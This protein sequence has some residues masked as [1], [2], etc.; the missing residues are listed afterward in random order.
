MNHKEILIKYY[1]SAY[2][3][4]H[5]SSFPDNIKTNVAKVATSSG[6]QKGVFTVLVTLLVHKIHSPQ[7]D[8]RYHQSSMKDGFSGRTIDTQYITPTLKELSMPSM[9][10]SGWLTRSLEQPYPYT[11]SYNG[12]IRELKKEFLEIVD[13]IQKTPKM[14][15]SVLIEILHLAKIEHKKNIVE[16]KPLDNC[17]KINI[18]KLAY[19]LE[20]YFTLKFESRGGSK[21]PVL[22]F[23]AIY[24]CLLSEMTRFKDCRLVELGSHTSSDRTSKSSGD[25]QITKKGK[26]FEVLEIKLNKPIDAN[27]VRVAKEKIVIHNPQRYYILSNCEINPTDAIVIS[28]LI[29]DIKRTHGCQLIVNGLIPTLKY[30]FRLLDD[31]KIFLNTF[32][33]L[34]SR[35]KELSPSH[36]NEWKKIITN[37]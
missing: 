17:E 30:Y 31:V 32:G 33:Q 6:T 22:A 8:I 23:Y 16:I 2:S 10:E 15:P 34:I 11:L 26:Q 35:D 27:V 18:T 9:A 29:D 19:Q 12:K 24:H 36:K 7:Q 5:T 4:R 1:N 20:K 13:F 37:L 21:L 25:I 28:E 3:T 14:A